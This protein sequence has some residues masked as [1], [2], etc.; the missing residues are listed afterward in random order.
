M[1]QYDNH[2]VELNLFYLTVPTYNYFSHINELE[3]ALSLSY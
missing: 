3:S 1:E 2:D